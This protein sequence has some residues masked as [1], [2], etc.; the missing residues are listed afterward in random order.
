M[1][2]QSI[3][4]I[5]EIAYKCHS[6]RKSAI[7]NGFSVSDPLLKSE[8]KIATQQFSKEVLNPNADQDISTKFAWNIVRDSNLHHIE[9]T[10]S[11]FM[12][13]GLTFDQTQLQRIENDLHI[14]VTENN[15][16]HTLVIKNAF[17]FSPD[18]CFHDILQLNF[19]DGTYYEVQLSA[20][21]NTNADNSVI[22]HGYCKAAAFYPAQE[23]E[24]TEDT[25]VISQ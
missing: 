2:A 17:D 24:I 4:G 16:P 20:I 8:L 7:K 12:P 13:F 9:K 18:T 19:Q 14:S 5:F 11:I 23:S 3:D 22:N 1:Y 25:E 15:T 10:S 6:L 21:S